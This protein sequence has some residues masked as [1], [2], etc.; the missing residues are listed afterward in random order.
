MENR[1][2]EE[3]LKGEN[4][5][6]FMTRC[7]LNP[8]LWY[9]RVLGL[10]LQPF[11]KEW[12]N[13]LFSKD[14]LVISAPTGFGKTTIFGVGFSLWMAYFKPNSVSL[15]VSKT[16]RTQSANI[17]EEIKGSIENNEI[18]MKLMPSDTKTYWT[19]EKI[20]CS[21][22]AQILYSSYSPNVRGIQ[23]DYVFAD[24]VAVYLDDV[25]Y[26]RDVATRVISKKGKIAAV[27]T[28]INTTDLLAQLLNNE[29]YYSKVYPAIVRN[30]SIWESKFPLKYL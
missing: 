27:S 1:T 11:H 28:P 2:K 14:R 4:E 26:Y 10:D 3:I 8:C 21:N 19:K 13:H 6:L 30:K 16:I 25:I 17:L 7:Y 22:G 29:A 24:E 9:E 20:R 23:A 5:R 15:I 12:I 18:L